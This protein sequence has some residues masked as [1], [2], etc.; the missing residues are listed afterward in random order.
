MNNSRKFEYGGYLPIET[1]FSNESQHYFKKQG[2]NVQYLNCGRTCFYVAAKSASIKKIYIP[3]FTCAETSQPFKDLGISIKFYKLVADLMPKGIELNKNEYLLWTNYYGN[4]SK[5]MISLIEKKY[6]GRLIIDS[7]HAFYCPPIK[8][9]FNCYSARKFIGVSDGAYLVTDLNI[10]PYSLK[11]IRDE[12]YLHMGHLFKQIEEGT[13]EGY[14]LSL[15]N[16]KRLEKNYK[17]MSLT[18][19]KILSFINHSKIKEIR[20]KNFLE[21]HSNLKS[22]NNFPVNLNSGTQMYYPFKCKDHKL[23][24]KLIKNRIYNP[25]WWRHVINELGERSVEGEY[26]LETVLLPIDQR[27]TIDDMKILSDIVQNL[28]HI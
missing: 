4:A 26:T 7:C 14:S 3:Y 20:N 21:L 15:A 9:A 12:S 22:I 13:N 6:S 18:T 10:K 11:L 19:E 16:E 24:D 5:E 23:R 8:G 1:H 27:Y 25:T 17:L 2:Q 28:I